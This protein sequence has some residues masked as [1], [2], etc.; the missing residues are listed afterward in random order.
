MPVNFFDS[1]TTISSAPSVLHIGTPTPYQG[2]G[3]ISRA[4][5]D[6]DPSLWNQNPGYAF[7][8]VSATSPVSGLGGF[9]EY[10]FQI[11]PSS[12]TQDEDFS[13]TP[14]AT[15]TGVF[16]EHEGFVFKRI[17]ISGTTGINP[18]RGIGG[19]SDIG[20]VIG[21][22]G[23][24]GYVDFATLINFLRS[25]AESKTDPNNA[26][27]RLVFKNFKDNEFWFV[28]PVRFSKKRESSRPFEYQY[29]IQLLII[30]KAERSSSSFLN[31]GGGFGKGF[32]LFNVLSNIKTSLNKVVL[33]PL[34]NALA[35]MQGGKN[36]LLQIEREVESTIFNPIQQVI[37]ALDAVVNGTTK[38]S[39]LPRNY[40]EDV[41][42][43]VK[44]VGDNVNDIFGYGND[45]YDDF[46]KRSGQ[47]K[48]PVPNTPVIQ[49]IN[50]MQAFLDTETALKF[51]VCTNGLFEEPV[52]NNNANYAAFFDNDVEIPEPAGVK[53]STI[54]RGDTIERIASRALGT[55]D[56]F[57]ELVTLNNLEPPYI[58]PSGQSTNPRVK[59]PGDAILIPVF[60]EYLNSNLKLPVR[61]SK[62][63]AGMTPAE[64]F[65]GVDLKLSPD[66]DL[67]INNVNDFDLIAGYNN[68]G[69]AVRIKL[70]L[71]KGSLITDPELGVGIGTGE[72]ITLSLSE[73][74]DDFTGS[75]LQDPRFS[76]AKVTK[77]ARIGGTLELSMNV[78]ISKLN[79]P[80]PVKVALD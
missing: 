68:A 69:Q 57:L 80:I 38:V 67:I 66:S 59:N 19:M 46:Y 23:N 35:L 18:R 12:I 28:E 16:V 26:D 11:N 27:S 51:V 36:F 45:S 52:T 30:G 33:G 15:Q 21:G 56:R 54:N 61:G 50:L 31:V 72:K 32:G 9:G 37:D 71:E 17:T 49:Q 13:I 1:P 44:R 78:M 14:R 24:S 2:N 22:V 5:Q 39:S 6:I 70:N 10:K 34:K 74:V 20:Q 42:V 76:D 3:A 58:D 47:V 41:G 7:A 29:G 43:E 79:Q 75:I 63:T 25:Y 77:A 60:A 65:M 53:E 4:I 64:K 48:N 73:I 55:S 62:L 8:V 40:Y